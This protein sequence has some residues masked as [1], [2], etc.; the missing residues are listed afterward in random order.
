LYKDQSLQTFLDD[1][2]SS[3]PTP[4]GGSTAAISGAMAAGLVCMVCRLTLGKPKYTDVQAEINTLLEHAEAQQQRF[5][6]LLAEDIAAYDTLSA[7]FKLPR[8]TD[9]EKQERATAVQKALLAAAL[10]PLEITERAV[11]VARICERVSQIGN[12]NVISDIAAS[13]ML[14]A[15]AGTAAAWMVRVNLQSF[16]DSALASQLSQ[17]LSA[18]LEELHSR[19][20]QVTTTVSNRA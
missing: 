10:V 4:G 20:Q 17:R 2:A 8:A 15:A 12:V 18:G 6:E 3:N 16:H 1:L 9:D 11:A 5:I 7:S 13:A 14:A 19:S